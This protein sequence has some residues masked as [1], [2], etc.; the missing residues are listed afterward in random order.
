MRWWLSGPPPTERILTGGGSGRGE[1]R[2]GVGVEVDEHVALGGARCPPATSRKTRRATTPPHTTHHPP[3]HSEEECWP[4][5]ERGSQWLGRASPRKQGQRLHPRH[6]A[7]GSGSPSGC[8][9][10]GPRRQRRVR[11]RRS[12][13]RSQWAAR[14]EGRGPGVGLACTS[15]R[16]A[17]SHVDTGGTRAEAGGIRMFLVAGG[18][19]PW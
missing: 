19:W 15:G 8:R 6:R 13:A 12:S 10:S 1:W 7:R 16:A 9:A 4:G 2:P 5:R 17:E 3:A 11:V 18:R 14:A